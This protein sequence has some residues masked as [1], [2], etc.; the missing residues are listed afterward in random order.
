MDFV[1]NTTV[2]EIKEDLH[3]LK[4]NQFKMFERFSDMDRRFSTLQAHMDQRFIDMEKRFT[5]IHEK[6]SDINGAIA[7]QTRWIL[8]AIIGA[9]TLISVVHPLL[10]KFL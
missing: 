8:F 6:I 7:V 9:A 10:M 3:T 2:R 1:E 5:S 4:Q